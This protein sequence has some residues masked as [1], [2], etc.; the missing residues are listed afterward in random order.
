MQGK[1][2]FI[3]FCLKIP[4]SGLSACHQ[5]VEISCNTYTWLGTQW[6]YVASCL[7]VWLTTLQ[8]PR[9]HTHTRTAIQILYAV[10]R[11]TTKE[12]ALCY[13]NRDLLCVVVCVCAWLWHCIFKWWFSLLLP[14]FGEN[15]YLMEVNIGT[16]KCW[17]LRASISIKEQFKNHTRARATTTPEC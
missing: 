9:A 15:V 16:P 7:H 2:K 5:A 12:D 1:I 17:C 13:P 10:T 11:Y 6:A 8:P 4:T 3:K 14:Q